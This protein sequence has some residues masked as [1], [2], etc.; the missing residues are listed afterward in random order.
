MRRLVFFLTMVVLGA[1]AQP[2]HADITAEY[3]VWGIIGPSMKVRV[4]V[5]G[6]ARVEMNDHPVAIRRDGVTYLVR[7]D[8]QGPFVLRKDEFDRIETQIGEDP[9]FAADAAGFDE[10]MIVEA[11]EEIVG[12][13]RGTVLLLATPGEPAGSA[14]MAFV[15]TQDPD[16]MPVGPVVAE[17]FGSVTGLGQNPVSDTIADIHARGTLIR[18]W[19]MIRLERTDDEPI[20]ASAFDLPGPIVNGEEARARLGAAW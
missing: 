12:G 14:E 11:G 10:V 17:I 3:Y 4:A 1:L 8:E 20:P 9:D 6:N 16:L 19:F 15:V 18:M 7:E 13:R 5:N 2:A